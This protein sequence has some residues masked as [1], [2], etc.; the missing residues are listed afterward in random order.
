VKEMCSEPLP[1]SNLVS[2]P[3]NGLLQQM[4]RY[5][6]LVVQ[7]EVFARRRSFRALSAGHLK[8]PW[9]QLLPPIAVGLRNLL[10]LNRAELCP[11]SSY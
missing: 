10:D 9:S 2:E 3:G 1:D 5:A 7:I 6:P 4:Q 8:L 11:E